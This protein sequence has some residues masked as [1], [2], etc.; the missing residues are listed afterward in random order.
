MRTGKMGQ[1]SIQD[2]SPYRVPKVFANPPVEG[3]KTLIAHNVESKA[4][5]S[6]RAYVAPWMS[7]HRALLRIP[8]IDLIP[9][10]VGEFL[11]SDQDHP[12]G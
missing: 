2:R 3:M 8:I 7:F 11:I 5:A 12:L 1:S 4:C 6:D 10:L 9:K